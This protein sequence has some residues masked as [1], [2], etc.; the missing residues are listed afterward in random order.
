MKSL[1]LLPLGSCKSTPTKQTRALTLQ[2]QF[3][4]F[5]L[6]GQ[7]AGPWPLAR[8]GAEWE[9]VLLSL[10]CSRSL[11]VCPATPTRAGLMYNGSWGSMGF[12]K[13]FLTPTSLIRCSIPG[14]KPGLVLLG[15]WPLPR[16]SSAGRG[17]GHTGIAILVSEGRQDHAQG[18]PSTE[19][20]AGRAGA[21]RE[22]FSENLKSDRGLEGCKEFS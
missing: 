5:L 9:S 10:Y 2:T 1:S 8:L 7:V 11:G 18:K 12:S 15:V 20:K 16:G 6:P 3:S 22:D 4:G 13:H 21:A 14:N 19:G 17:C